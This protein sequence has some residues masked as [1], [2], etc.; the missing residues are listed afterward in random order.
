MR[1]DSE[2]VVTNCA[3][4]DDAGMATGRLCDQGCWSETPASRAYLASL[5]DGSKPLFEDFGGEKI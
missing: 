4:V 2:V 3:F 1:H 5:Q